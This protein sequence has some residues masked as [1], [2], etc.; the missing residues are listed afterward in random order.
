MH[1]RHQTVWPR[2]GAVAERLWSP[3]N[4]ANADAAHARMQ[5]FRC[6]LNHRAVA[7]C[8]L[9]FACI[10]VLHAQSMKSTHFN[11]SFLRLLLLTMRKLVLLLLA[12]A[13]VIING[14][15]WMST[16]LIEPC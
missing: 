3:R 12:L 9:V 15:S 7:V 2:L 1:C 10:Y 4:V 6:L 5:A 13:L 16:P 11:G 8:S 14:P